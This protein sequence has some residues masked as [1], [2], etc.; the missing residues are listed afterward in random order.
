MPKLDDTE[1]LPVPGEL[2][3]RFEIRSPNAAGGMFVGPPY[4]IRSRKPVAD[5][6]VTRACALA[7]MSDIALMAAARPPGTAFDLSTGFAASL[8]HS[9]WF[10]RPFDPERWHH[11]QAGPVNGVDAR[12]LA[13]GGLYDE[14]GSLIATMA[15]EALWR[16]GS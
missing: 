2:S 1:L 16:G 5:D 8:D 6:P 11:Y 13:I 15:Q 7:Y 9:V 12:G 10:H 14:A 3:E 4:W